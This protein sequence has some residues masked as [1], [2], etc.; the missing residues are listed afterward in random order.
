MEREKKDNGLTRGKKKSW[1]KRRGY[2]FIFAY[3]RKVGEKEKG[4]GVPASVSAAFP[5]G[6]GRERGEEVRRDP[7]GRREDII[8]PL[9]ARARKKEKKKRAVSLSISIGC[10]RGRK[11][12]II[13]SIML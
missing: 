3:H 12:G 8:G 10:E 11:E 2:R 9:P 1:R 6:E 13:R 7:T 5:G 4:R